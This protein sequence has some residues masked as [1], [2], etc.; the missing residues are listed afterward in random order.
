MSTKT[1]LTVEEFLELPDQPGK[2]ELLNGELISLPPAKLEHSD[3][4]L[5]LFELLRS[6]LSKGRVRIE[7]G[8]RLHHSILQPD[9]SVTWPDQRVDRG[10]LGGAPMLAVEVVS[11]SNSA[12]EI[13]SKIAVYLAEGAAEVWVIYPK[14]GIMTVSNRERT[15]RFSGEYPCDLL[16]L[17][18]DL[19]RL[20]HPAR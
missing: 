6:V 13:E 3:I 2:Q 17:T 1:L 18:V 10:W 20:L 12:E 19:Q 14:P 9:V 4:S 8:Y 5:E 15:L 7:T 16:G 11:P